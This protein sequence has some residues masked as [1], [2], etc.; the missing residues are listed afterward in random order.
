MQKI[1]IIEDDRTISEGLEAALQFHE[2]AVF[3]AE[4]SEAGL[5][6]VRQKKP[7]L[8]I[9]DIML[10]GLDGFAA[11]KKIRE[12]DQ[13]L[14]IIMLTAK[15]QESDKL[16]G[17]E[18]GADDYVTK[19]F[20]AK[21]LIA[22]VRAVLKRT[23]ASPASSAKQTVTIGNAIVNFDNF[24]L[25]KGA[26]EFALSPK[27]HDILKLFVHHPDTVIS[28]SRII[29]EVWGDEYFPSPKTI[30]NFVVKLRTKIEDNPKK[31][32]HILTVHGAGYKFK[33]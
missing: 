20:S 27:E 25:C 28:R 29:D 17:F 22:R 30:D 16:L 14:P 33:F 13:H 9:L 23:S 31:P 24:T 26:D 4:S 2:F 3:C 12:Q 21:E 15:S 19:P 1:L 6:L 7:D 32:Q 18:L 10:P 8:V 11:C 5:P